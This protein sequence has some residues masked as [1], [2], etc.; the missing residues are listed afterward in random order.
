MDGI[1]FPQKI[2][3]LCWAITAFLSS[4]VKLSGYGMW[5]QFKSTGISDLN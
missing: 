4:P 2:S 3:M 1:F 5:D